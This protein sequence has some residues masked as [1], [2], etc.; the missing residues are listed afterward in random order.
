MSGGVTFG[1]VGGRASADLDLI[2]L[3]STLRHVHRFADDG[4]LLSLFPEPVIAVVPH[5]PPTRSGRTL[6]MNTCPHGR[7]LVSLV[8]RD[9]LRL[10]YVGWRL[11]DQIPWLRMA[12]VSMSGNGDYSVPA[13]PHGHRP[14]RVSATTML[15]CCVGM[16]GACGRIPT[17][18]SAGACICG[19]YGRHIALLRLAMQKRL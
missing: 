15:W 18:W 19:A 13:R 2:G 8:A 14:R 10:M 1:T 6:V 11:I 5:H 4:A 7:A 3:V 12:Q 17:S 9:H 16:Y